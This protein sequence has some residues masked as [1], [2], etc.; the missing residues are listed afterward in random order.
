MSEN[1]KCDIC[2]KPATVHL[3]QIIGD[4][5]QKMNLCE[6][7]AQKKNIAQSEAFSLSELLAKTVTEVT[8]A[9]GN[10]AAN[11]PVC[12]ECGMTP[13]DYKKLGRLGCPA[14]YDGLKMMIAPMLEQMQHGTH[15]SGKAPADNDLHEEMHRRRK[16]LETR[17]AAAVREERYEEAARLRDE[18]AGLDVPPPPA[19]NTSEHPSA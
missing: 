5:I 18:L 17:M 11:M 3:T 1:H 16:D 19:P 14:C 2:G 10:A 13:E 8:Q 7:C 6:E 9:I 4:K 15:H 12:P